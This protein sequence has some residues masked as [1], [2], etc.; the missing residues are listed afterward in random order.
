MPRSQGEKPYGALRS[1]I[2]KYYI[3]EQSCDMEMTKAILSFETFDDEPVSRGEMSAPCLTKQ[4]VFTDEVR[5]LTDAVSRL[6]ETFSQCLLRLIDEKKRR[7]SEIYK[8]ANIDRRVFS[9]IR[10]NKYYRPS[11]NTALAF[12]VALEL[13]LDD[14]RDFLMKA[15]FALSRSSKQDVIVEY[16]ISE[17]N[18][19][20][21]EI[22]EALFAFDQSLLG[23]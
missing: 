7:D 21:Y 14:T 9:K 23:A 3:D 16:F 2:D 1:Y 17:K 10:S 20:I 19:N 12:A 4:A 6:E 15:G 5:S 8:R 13:S 22:N 11:K 18:Y